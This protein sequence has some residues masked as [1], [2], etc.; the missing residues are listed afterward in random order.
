VS[1]MNETV[2]DCVDISRVADEGIPFVDGDLAGEDRR[3]AAVT[4]L[5]DFVEVATGARRRSCSRRM[6]KIVC[7]VREVSKMSTAPGT[8]NVAKMNRVGESGCCRYERSGGIWA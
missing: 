8:S 2:E 7:G 6:T 4:F 1:V 3:T 5:E